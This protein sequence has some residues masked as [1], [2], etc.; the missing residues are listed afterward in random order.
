MSKQREKLRAII[1]SLL[2]FAFLGALFQTSIYFYNRNVKDMERIEIVEKVSFFN[3]GVEETLVNNINLLKG[4]RAYLETVEVFD[5]EKA[6]TYLANLIKEEKTLIRNVGIIEDTTIVWNYPKKGNQDAI[7]VDLL[8]IES[9]RNDTIK[10]KLTLQQVMLGPVDLVQG[11]RG[12]IVRIPIIRENSYWGQISIVLDADQFFAEVDELATSHEIKARID[13]ISDGET[14]FVSDDISLEKSVSILV[15]F[16]DDDYQ[17]VAEP[18]NDWSKTNFSIYIMSVLSVVF[19]FAVSLL[20]LITLESKSK[21]K[22][23]AYVDTLTSLKNRLSLKSNTLKYYDFGFESESV[24]VVIIDVDNFKD[25][26]DTYGHENGDKVLV[27]FA[28]RLDNL[29][30][31]ESLAYRL[32]GDEFLLAV[33]L[34]L[35]TSG[36]RQVE[37]ELTN[38]LIFNIDLAGE[39]Y[40]VQSSYGISISNQ[41]AIEVSDL[42]RLADERMYQ[43]KQRKQKDI[44]RKD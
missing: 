3:A 18:I 31:V 29:D 9:Q 33:N 14:L 32:G 23:L 1:L 16:L 40:H 17:F 43:D 42:M 2:T 11:G 22:E 21:M 41:D 4:F 12:I 15:K 24:A 10:V 44:M 37:Y 13:R 34:D 39:D 8:S 30:L 27:E 6:E 5:D 25:I 20:L 38:K 19:S 7:G 35:E 28:K 36:I 26:N